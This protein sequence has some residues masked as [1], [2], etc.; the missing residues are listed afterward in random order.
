ML[1]RSST[2]NESGRTLARILRV[3]TGESSSSQTSP[4]TIFYIS[5][6]TRPIGDFLSPVESLDSYKLPQI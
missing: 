6:S 5:T 1:E 2:L 4:N 3:W